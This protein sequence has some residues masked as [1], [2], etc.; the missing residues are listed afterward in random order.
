MKLLKAIW[1][2]LKSLSTLYY[3]PEWEDALNILVAV[4]ARV[5]DRV[6]ADRV[7]AQFMGEL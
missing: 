3:D 4:D 2:S 7:A 6:W 1:K 5:P